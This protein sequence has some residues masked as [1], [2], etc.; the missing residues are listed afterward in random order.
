MPPMSQQLQ[1]IACDPSNKN[2]GGRLSTDAVANTTPYTKGEE[3]KQE[4]DDLP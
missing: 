3:E 4:S 2:G 1:G